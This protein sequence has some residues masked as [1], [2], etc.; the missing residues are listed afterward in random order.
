MSYK[1]L[2]LESLIIPN[3]KF[4]CRFVFV[5]V[6]GQNLCV[7]VLTMAYSIGTKESDGELRILLVGKTG[8]GKSS[9]GNTLL[10]KQAF[11]TSR[12]LSSVTKETQCREAVR[13]GR[14]L[15]IVDTPGFY[16]TGSSNME[17]VREIVRIFGFLSPGIHVLMYIMGVERFTEECIKTKDLVLKTFGEGIKTRIIIVITHFDDLEAEHVDTKKYLASSGREFLQFQNKCNNR[18]FFIN[19]KAKSDVLDQQVMSLIKIADD[20]T[21]QHGGKCYTNEHLKLVRAYF[22]LERKRKKINLSRARRMLFDRASMKL[23]LQKVVAWDEDKKKPIPLRLPKGGATYS[24]LPN[25]P[26]NIP[27]VD[28]SKVERSGKVKIK[29]VPVRQTSVATTND[30][31]EPAKVNTQ[32]VHT[33]EGY[34]S[35]KDKDEKK[36]GKKEKEHAP[37]LTTDIEFETQ[38]VIECIEDE[39]EV[40]SEE[41]ESSDTENNTIDRQK[42]QDKSFF[43]KF[44]DFFVSLFSPMLD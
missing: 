6:N 21:R 3:K 16:D 19:N 9:T 28:K 11:R 18:V 40:G 20:V 27:T 38:M 24:A 29:A 42:V 37:D 33:S 30:R 5:Y 25:I 15:T 39:H 26:R 12:S 32:S 43:D 1:Q 35:A 4:E 23:G 44:A 8:V 41:A 13:F 2:W 7:S 34:G 14:R 36:E 22:R 10:G 17:I 31:K